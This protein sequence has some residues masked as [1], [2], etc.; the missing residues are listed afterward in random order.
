MISLR[1]LSARV[2]RIPA[3][4]DFALL[5]ARLPWIASDRQ[6]LGLFLK[7]SAVE[8]ASFS[9]SL[10]LGQEFRDRSMPRIGRGSART[11]RQNLN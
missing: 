2:L 11:P 1:K 9:W 8:C 3:I 7:P 10:Q 5:F 4:I 6:A